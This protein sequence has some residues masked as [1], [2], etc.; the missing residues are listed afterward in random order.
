MGGILLSVFGDEHDN[1]MALNMPMKTWAC[2]PIT[3]FYMLNALSLLIIGGDGE[4]GS[5]DASG[6]GFLEGLGCNAQGSA[7]CGYIVDQA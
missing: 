1:M 2:H 5:G 6:A 7:G 4:N 3:N